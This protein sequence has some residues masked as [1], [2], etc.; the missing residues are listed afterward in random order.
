MLKRPIQRG[1]VGAGLAAGNDFDELHSTLINS[2]LSLAQGAQRTQR[3]GGFYAI[4]WA[5]FSN[6]RLPMLHSEPCKSG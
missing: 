1:P 3:K 5:V 2:E 6:R 4:R